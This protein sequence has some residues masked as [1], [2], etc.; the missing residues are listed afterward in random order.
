MTGCK[1]NDTPAVHKTEQMGNAISVK[2]VRKCF[3]LGK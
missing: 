1:G 2:E 3:E